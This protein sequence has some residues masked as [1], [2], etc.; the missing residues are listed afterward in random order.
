MADANKINENL[1]SSAD[2]LMRETGRN[3]SAASDAVSEGVSDA[4]ER[5]SGLY[6]AGNAAVA[7]R[8]DVLPG[9]VTAALAGVV[10][11]YFIGRDRPHRW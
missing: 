11:G 9:M 10:V 5:A 7:N 6:A 4:A 3:V 2:A 1:P 8:I